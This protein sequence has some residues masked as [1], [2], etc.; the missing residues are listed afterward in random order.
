MEAWK[1][2]CM[3][4]H[5]SVCVRM[6]NRMHVYAC[7]CVRACLYVCMYRCYGGWMKEGHSWPRSRFRSGHCP[8]PF[9]PTIP[10]PPRG[11]QASSAPILPISL[12]QMGFLRLSGACASAL[13]PG[14]SQARTDR[15][16]QGHQEGVTQ[17]A[18]QGKGEERGPQPQGPGPHPLG[19]LPGTEADTGAA[20]PPLLHARLITCVPRSTDPTPPTNPRRPQRGP[21]RSWRRP[22]NAP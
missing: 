2:A 5:L 13:G 15:Q 18:V 11:S 21:G 19:E 9:R 10:L 20:A 12:C 1:T 7:A 14:H 22:P 16:Q 6:Y 3:H 4:A 17:A 8:A